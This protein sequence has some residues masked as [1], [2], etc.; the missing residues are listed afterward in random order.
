MKENNKNRGAFN[1]IY[2][3]YVAHL[4]EKSTA[5]CGTGTF[6]EV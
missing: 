1:G 5:H 3:V 2:F 6:P 4:T